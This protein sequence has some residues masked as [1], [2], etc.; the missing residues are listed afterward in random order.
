MRPNRAPRGP[1]ARWTA[2]SA[3]VLAWVAL[4]CRSA[5]P[6]VPAST[7]ADHPLLGTTPAP[8]S[9]PTLDGRLVEVP[10]PGRIT[11][12]DF[13]ATFCGPCLPLLPKLEAVHRDFEGQGVTVI[14]VAADDTPGLVQAA[15]R[16]RGI[17]YPN[18]VAGEQLQGAFFVRTLPQTVVFDRQGRARLVLTGAQDEPIR[19]LRTALEALV[20]EERP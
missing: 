16:T 14:G 8:R 6:G 18:V 9:A 11:V 3:V 20:N 17:T 12:V 7:P 10:V 13:W 1:F 2:L 19:R 5:A 4:A 15:L